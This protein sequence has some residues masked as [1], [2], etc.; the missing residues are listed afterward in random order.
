MKNIILIIIGFV[1][2]IGASFIFTQS[3][4]PQ[5]DIVQD[6]RVAEV[7]EMM[8]YKDLRI[9]DTGW[10]YSVSPKNNT[11]LFVSLQLT[12]DGK[13]ISDISIFNTKEYQDFSVKDTDSD[14]TMDFWSFMD[15][16]SLFTYAR[17]D[18]YPDA[19]LS[20]PDKLIVRIGDKY[21]TTRKIDKKLFIEQ[22]GNLVEIEATTNFC[23][24]IKK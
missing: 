19:I 9:V 17:G 4:I 3:K 13:F 15:D 12:P 22:N 18:G 21:F 6:E 10:L 24:A 11:N 16:D 20:E 2:G 5:P 1:L 23:Y 8:I 14:G 7:P